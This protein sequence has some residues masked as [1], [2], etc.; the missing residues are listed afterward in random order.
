MKYKQYLNWIFIILKNQ[1]TNRRLWNFL[2]SGNFRLFNFFLPNRK[3]F[4]TLRVSL[5]C[6]W[7]EIGPLFLSLFWAIS[8]VKAPILRLPC[9]RTEWVTH[10]PLMYF[11]SFP[12]SN[13]TLRS[14]ISARRSLP[15]PIFFIDFLRSPLFPIDITPTPI[16]HRILFALLWKL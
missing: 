14:S 10:F 6:N 3:T 13:T 15:F 2:E 11:T 5:L 4:W 16:A 9:R 8:F 12:P 1:K 7:S